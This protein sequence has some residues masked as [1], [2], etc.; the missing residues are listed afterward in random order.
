[1]K[2]VTGDF[3]HRG[4]DEAVISV[5]RAV[6]SSQQQCYYYVAFSPDGNFVT[7][8][9]F[10][11]YAH[12][13]GTGGVFAF[14]AGSEAD[15]LTLDINPGKY[16]GDELVVVG[17]F[18]FGV[19][20]PDS[21]MFPSVLYW[22]DTVYVSA[23]ARRLN[24]RALAVGDIDPDTSNQEW[25]PEIIVAEHRADTST[26]LRV[27]RPVVNASNVFTGMTERP[28]IDAGRH[29]VVSALTAADLDGDA[30]RFGTP[31]LVTVES[32]VQPI[33]VMGGPPTHDN[34]RGQAYDLCSAYDT[35]QVRR[36][37]VSYTET[38]GSATHLET[39][40]SHSSGSSREISGGFSLFG[41]KIEGYA[42][43]AFESGY[44]GSHSVNK[45]ITTTSIQKSY[46]DD[47]MLGTESSLELWEYPVYALDRKLGTYL[48]QMPRYIRTLW[49]PYMDV[50]LRDWMA[51]REVGNLLSYRPNTRI[52]SWAGDNLLATFQTKTIAQASAAGFTVNFGDS[53]VDETRLTH[54]VQAEVGLSVSK[55]GV[56]AKVS[57]HYSDAAG[58]THTIKV[59]RNVIVD[60]KMGD[61][62]RAYSDANYYVTPY[63]YWGQNGA[64]V[65]DYGIRSPSNGIPYSARSGTRTI[66]R[67]PIPDSYSVAI[68]FA[69]EHRGCQRISVTT[70]RAS[71]CRRQPR[72]R[73]TRCTSRSVCT[74]SVSS[75]QAGSSPSGAIWAIQ[76]AG[77][78]RSSGSGG[79]HR[80]S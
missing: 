80:T 18:G 40:I 52:T 51:D 19:V 32:F 69:E 22:K 49:L 4:R 50:T 24:L 33:V 54:S 48:V 25:V 27:F 38:Q 62:N 63:L 15:A 77:A 1:M 10:F 5:V 44:Y 39:N 59:S 17:P 56:E 72:M 76:R 7:A 58:S 73:A 79:R 3:H 66:S 61:L 21:A 12:Y 16:D 64:L 26:V 9:T 43:K 42:K 70:A 65:L 11:N 45:T 47:W 68:G 46:R 31:N 57:G 37:E 30:I 2:I 55:W 23:L 34:L 29:S 71:M 53:T 67:N 14:H 8:S 28:S 20:K 36:F 74:I 41:I 78:R 13:L 75:R 35:S 6:F 60:I